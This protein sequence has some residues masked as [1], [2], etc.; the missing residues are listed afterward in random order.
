VEGLLTVNDILEAL[1]GEITAFDQQV[2]ED[3]VQRNDGSWLMD[4]MLPL[5][6]VKK[7]LKMKKLPGE[8]LGTFQT[9]GGLMMAQLGR[10][11]KVTDHFEWGGLRFEV[12]DMDR[13]RVDKVLVTDNRRK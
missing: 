9:L 12:V 5:S 3:I 7:T 2:E 8:D 4:G 6:K 11:P 1:V 10:I 13:N